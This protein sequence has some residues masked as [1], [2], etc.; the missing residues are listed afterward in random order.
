MNEET[1]S[2]LVAI[3]RRVRLADRVAWC[4][5]MLDG[6][7]ARV[8]IEGRS[9]VDFAL[10]D[11]K[12]GFQK[13]V[14]VCASGALKLSRS[15]AV[16]LPSYRTEGLEVGQKHRAG[17]CLGANSI[18]RQGVPRGGRVGLG[19]ELQRASR[20]F[21]VLPSTWTWG[22]TST[23]HTSLPLSLPFILAQAVNEQN[24]LSQRIHEPESV[25]L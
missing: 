19:R 23:S 13:I 16:E 2:R 5:W 21:D 6:G 9:A 10:D 1:Q 12:I 20:R 14:D 22:V 17:G 24:C 7:F 8:A 25:K 4:C 15:D 11:W 3:S 18:K